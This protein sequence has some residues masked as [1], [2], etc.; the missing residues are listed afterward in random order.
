[1]YAL[2]NSREGNT[3]TVVGRKGRLG[4]TLCPWSF[5][6][7]LEHQLNSKKYNESLSYFFII[8]IKCHDQGKR[9]LSLELT[10]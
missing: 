3:D 1:M 9:V 10:D 6:S 4:D 7:N 2:D 5:V 8:L